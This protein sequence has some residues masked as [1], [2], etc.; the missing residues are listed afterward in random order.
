MNNIIALIYDRLIDWDTY[1]ELSGMV[2]S[3]QD[4]G[5]LGWVLIIVPILV[6]TIFYK[7]WDP[8]SNSK[9][10]WYVAIMLIMLISYT[11]TSIILY[12]NFEI[13]KFIGNFTGANGEPDA[14]YFIFQMSAITLV[15]AFIISFIISIIPFRLISTNNR[16]N[17]F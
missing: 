4:Y 16:Y 1:Q 2:F 13:I 9:L 6:L 11:G 17:P 5:K 7:F 12:N 3:N 10:K 8:V 14:D 15:Y